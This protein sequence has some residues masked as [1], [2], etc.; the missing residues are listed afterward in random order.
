MWGSEATV[1][2]P[3]SYVSSYDEPSLTGELLMAALFH[4]GKAKKGTTKL[5]EMLWR[6]KV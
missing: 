6:I 3:Q 2:V 1:K 5:T 4:S